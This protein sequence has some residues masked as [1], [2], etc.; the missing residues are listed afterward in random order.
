MSTTK[1]KSL[2]DGIPSKA[3]WP[4]LRSGNKRLHLDDMDPH[5]SIEAQN[6]IDD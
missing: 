5:N 4:G 3:H 6:K 1:E 2:L